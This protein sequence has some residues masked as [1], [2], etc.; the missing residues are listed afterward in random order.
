MS[1]DKPKKVD[2][3][4]VI[5]LFPGY[6]VEPFPWGAA[7]KDLKTGNYTS[8]FFPDGQELD[9]EHWDCI[10]HENGIQFIAFH[11]K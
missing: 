8:C 9:L 5:Q 11:K 6:E 10:L 2:M 1:K 7:V 4:K 3:P